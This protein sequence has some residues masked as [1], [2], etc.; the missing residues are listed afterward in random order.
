M[1]GLK[2]YEGNSAL[3]MTNYIKNYKDTRRKSKF[4]MAYES[5]MRSSGFNEFNRRLLELVDQNIQNFKNNQ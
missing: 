3:K 2:K 4:D 1:G 5:V